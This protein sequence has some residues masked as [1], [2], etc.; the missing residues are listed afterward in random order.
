M[1]V[2]NERA[3]GLIINKVIFGDII[4]IHYLYA[5]TTSISSY[6]FGVFEE[7]FTILH[8]IYP[9]ECMYVDARCAK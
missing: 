8:L 1:H 3:K 5:T 2:K 7:V 4:S 6:T 9:E